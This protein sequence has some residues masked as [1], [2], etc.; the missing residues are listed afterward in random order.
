MVLP[1]HFFAA[2]SLYEDLTEDCACRT[3]LCAGYFENAGFVPP[4]RRRA[5]YTTP[6]FHLMC[7]HER[8]W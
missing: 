8:P 6:L 5:A 3:A 4:R 2:Y 7:M 1:F